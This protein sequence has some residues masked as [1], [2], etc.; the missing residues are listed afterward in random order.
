MGVAF[1]AKTT[2]RE[3]AVELRRDAPLLV[4]DLL[5][6]RGGG[7]REG[8]IRTEDKDLLEHL[9]Q[10]PIAVEQGYLDKVLEA[11]DMLKCVGE[12]ADD[13]QLLHRRMGHLL[14]KLTCYCALRMDG[15]HAAHGTSGI[16]EGNL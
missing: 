16:S 6:Q 4:P 13:L 10:D 8:V 15:T 12:A 2:N 14:V 11:L 9:G 5:T 3:R 7:G 1:W